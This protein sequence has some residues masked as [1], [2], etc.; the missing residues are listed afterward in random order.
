MAASVTLVFG[1]KEGES[2]ILDKPAVVVGRDETCDIRIDNL[3]I[4]RAHCQFLKRGTAWL[5]QDMNSANGSYVNGRKV[6]EHYLNDRDEVVLGKYSLVFHAD[7][8]PSSDAKPVT[9]ASGEKT[10]PAGGPSDVLHTYVMDG[11]QIRDRLAEIKGGPQPAQP[12]EQDPLRP[13]GPAAAKRPKKES[14][15]V[16]TWLYFLVAANV[17]LILV[18]V[19]IIMVFLVF[20]KGGGDAPVPPVLPVP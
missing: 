12:A 9:A 11:A 14:T 13:H 16:K 20:G 5:L 6:G 15:G 1:G 17:L 4:S 18:F 2:Y 7:T 19:A 8:A 10:G 3:G